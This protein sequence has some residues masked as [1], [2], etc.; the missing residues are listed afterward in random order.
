MRSVIVIAC[1]MGLVAATCDAAPPK[2]KD[3]PK[4]LGEKL[5]GNW[6]RRN[7][8]WSFAIQ[9]NRLSEFQ[10]SKPGAAHST[11]VLEFPAGK[12]YATVRLSHGYVL[13]IFPAGDDAIAVE[14][15]KPDGSI[16][17]DGRLFYRPDVSP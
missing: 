11:G 6:S 14:T 7:H 15:F 16:W 12:D 1:L 9:G 3:K 13:W 17:E 5:Q 2:A 10:E 8:Q 4:S